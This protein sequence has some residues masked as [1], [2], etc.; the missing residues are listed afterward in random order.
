[1]PSPRPLFFKSSADSF[2][3]LLWFVVSSGFIPNP[4]RVRDLLFQRQPS[5]S[6]APEFSPSRK[7]WEKEA[8]IASAVGATHRCNTFATRRYLQ[9]APDYGSLSHENKS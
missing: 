9:R 6:G 8:R 2:G 5:A 4:L 7:R 3:S 1:M